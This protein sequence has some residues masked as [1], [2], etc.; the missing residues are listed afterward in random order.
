MIL[1]D[2]FQSS[3]IYQN[4][5]LT[6]LERKFSSSSRHKDFV[7]FRVISFWVYAE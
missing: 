3:L 7:Y 6:D 4:S 1:V 5:G 2:V